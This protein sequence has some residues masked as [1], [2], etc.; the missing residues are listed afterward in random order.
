MNKIYLATT[1]KGK[2]ESMNN[3]LKDI[4]LDLDIEMIEYDYEEHKE[5]GTT[6]RIV[7]DGAEYLA[8]KYNKNIL[9][10]DVGIFIKELNG[11]PGVNT[12]F[13]ISKIGNEG[14]IKLLEDKKDRSVDWILSIGYCEPNKKPIEFTSITKGKISKEVK[15]GEGFGFDFIFIPNSYDKTLSEDIRI[16]EIISPFRSS[17]I[18]FGKW[19]KENKKTL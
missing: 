8:N 12:K 17:I 3:I 18:E 14:I 5:E 13:S 9:V 10:T 1:N 7:L 4:N 19:Y 11:F 2:V 15:E 16:R 6:S